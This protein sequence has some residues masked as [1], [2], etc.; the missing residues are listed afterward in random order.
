MR[1]LRDLLAAWRDAK[2]LA[3]RAV[4][5]WMFGGWCWRRWR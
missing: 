4:F 1:E 3:W 2:R 5:G